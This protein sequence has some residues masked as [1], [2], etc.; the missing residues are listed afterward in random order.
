MSLIEQARAHLQRGA[1]RSAEAAT[2]DG[3]APAQHQLDLFGT[4]T[5]E[6]SQTNLTS[7]NPATEE[8]E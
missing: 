7:K 1:Q 6:P 4:T 5:A 8:T 2:D 3:G